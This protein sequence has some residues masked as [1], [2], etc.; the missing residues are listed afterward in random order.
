MEKWD[1]D[2]IVV[3]GQDIYGNNI[4]DIPSQMNI[5]PIRDEETAFSKKF[6]KFYHKRFI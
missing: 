6:K 1:P 2:D 3:I 5:Y 4:L